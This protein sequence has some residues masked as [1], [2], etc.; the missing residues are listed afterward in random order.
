M[1]ADEHPMFNSYAVPKHFDDAEARLRFYMR[2]DAVPTLAGGRH[3]LYV[4][5]VCTR[6]FYTA[7]RRAYPRLTKEQLAHLGS[8]FHA[9][10]Q[11]LHLL[12]RALCPICSTIYL[13]GLFTIETYWQDAA[14]RCRGYHLLWESASPPYTSLVA[15]VCRPAHLPLRTLISREPETGLSAMQEVR[16]FLAWLETRRCPAAARVYSDEERQ[17]LARRLSPTPGIPGQDEEPRIWWGYGWREM[18]LPLDA[19]VLVALAV[20]VSPLAPAPLAQLLHAWRVLARVMR[21]VL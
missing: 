18:C 14:A 15:M 11:A 16:A 8:T 21:T 19:T 4:C 5:P 20:T 9:D 13:D 12:P 7:G 10:V 17:L 1:I 3:L 6:P 2:Q